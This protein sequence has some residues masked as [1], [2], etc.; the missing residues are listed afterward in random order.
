[1]DRAFSRSVALAALLAA[2]SPPP[3]AMD[4]VGEVVAEPLPPVP[5]PPGSDLYDEA[6][7]PRESDQRIAGLVL[8]RGLTKVD[9]LSGPL[10]HAFHSEVPHDKLLRYFGPRLVTGDVEQRGAAVTYRNATPRGVRGGVVPLEVRIEATSSHPA[11]VEI[12]ESPPPR[13]DQG[14]V[15]AEEVRRHFA[16][17]AREAE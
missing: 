7:L 10:R 15:S 16:A 6:G 2:C 12:V 3:V 8:P 4:G 17:Q 1:M 11:Y 14:T 9:A 13:S 5:P